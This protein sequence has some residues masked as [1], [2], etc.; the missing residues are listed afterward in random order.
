VNLAALIMLD[1]CWLLWIPPVVVRVRQQ[2][3]KSS[4]ASAGAS[5]WGLLLEGVAYFLAWFRTVRAGP[6]GCLI[7]A[8]ILAPFSTA[9][10]WM[11]V[12]HLGRQWRIKAG[13]YA[14]HEL[15]RSGPYRVVRHPIYASMLGMLVA[16]GLILTQWPLLLLALAFFVA[17]TEIR[18]RAEDGLL[19]ARFG[20]AFRRYQTGVPAYIPFV[21]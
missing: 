4:V 17:G 15:V 21:R 9:L 13:L 1:V 8:M 12:K 7:A 16:T 6:E 20:E 18:I 3:G 14:D 19:A 11:A 10:F 5:L 2:R